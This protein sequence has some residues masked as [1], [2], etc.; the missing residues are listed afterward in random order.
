MMKGMIFIMMGLLPSS[1]SGSG[2]GT[3]T[4]SS[5][6]SGLFAGSGLKVVTAM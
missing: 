6:S 1:G 2:G 4:F 3:V 5:L